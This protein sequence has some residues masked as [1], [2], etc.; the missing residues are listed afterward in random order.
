MLYY[1]DLPY[2]LEIICSKLISH[3]HDDLL[4]RPFGIDKT[5]ELIAKKYYWPSLRRDIEAYVKGFD[6][7]LASKAV[8]HKLYRDL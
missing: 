7:C 2:V 3:H 1:Q 5:Q 4:V 8:Y 6:V